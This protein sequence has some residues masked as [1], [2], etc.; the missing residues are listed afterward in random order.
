MIEEGDEMLDRIVAELRPLPAVDDTAKARVLIAIAA[1]RERDREALRRR[2]AGGARRSWL[3]RGVGLAAAAV[4]GVVLLRQPSETP[5]VQ[6][7]ALAPGGARAAPTQLAARSVNDADVALQ[8][9]QLVFQSAAATRVRVVGDFNGWDKEQ[10][11]MTRDPASGLWSATVRLR[12]GRH[13]Y[14]FVVDDTLWVRDPRAAAAQDADFGRP[15]S[16]ILVGR[17]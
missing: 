1:E 2:A 13:V 4:V 17:P 6:S 15:G 7:A 14:A 11:P 10:A 8:P 5:V 12:P 3:M 16:V 9:V